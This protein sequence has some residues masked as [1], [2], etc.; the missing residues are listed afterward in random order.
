VLMKAANVFVIQSAR[1]R[2][3]IAVLEAL[4]RS[5]PVVTAAAPGN[6]AQYLAVRSSRSIVCDPSAPGVAVAL[7][8]ML[9]GSG[10]RSNDDDGIDES[11]LAEYNWETAAGRV[12]EAL[13]I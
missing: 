12:A 11:W 13:V 8:Q 3:G 2:F 5:L 9:A 10:A 7:K 1:E 4:T 6:L